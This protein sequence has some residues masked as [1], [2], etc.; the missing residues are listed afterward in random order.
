VLPCICQNECRDLAGTR[1]SNRQRF[2]DRGAW[3]GTGDFQAPA[4]SGWSAIGTS[5]ISR[6]S[7]PI[8]SCLNSEQLFGERSRISHEYCVRDVV[9]VRSAAAGE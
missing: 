4:G 5:Y 6:L 7:L 9:L 1:F 3:F 2:R 8:F